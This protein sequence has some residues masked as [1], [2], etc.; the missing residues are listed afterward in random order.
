MALL[1]CAPPVFSNIA[2]NSRPAAPKL[3]RA[4]CANGR[5]CGKHDVLMAAK[6]DR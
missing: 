1:V 4:N 3:Q 5:R 6:V 2:N